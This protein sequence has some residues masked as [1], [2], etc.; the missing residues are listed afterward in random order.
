M[1]RAGRGQRRAWR[2]MVRTGCGQG[3]IVLQVLHP[4][5]LILLFKK[6]GKL[7]HLL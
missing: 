2:G 6:V 4:I 5:Q 1:L 7:Q 3:R